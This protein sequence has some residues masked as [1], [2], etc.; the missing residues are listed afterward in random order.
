MKDV[1][2][3]VESREP[4]PPTMRSS[5]LRQIHLLRAPQKVLFARLVRDLRRTH[6]M[7]LLGYRSMAELVEDRLQ[8]SER[9][10]RNR[11]AESLLFE[12][13]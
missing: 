9:S 10:A 6:A 2:E 3:L 5:A 12:T 11:V 1:E 4:S 13:R 7:D 8:P